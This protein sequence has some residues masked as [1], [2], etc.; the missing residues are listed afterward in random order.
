LS[1]AYDVLPFMHILFL[2]YN[3]Q[4]SNEIAIFQFDFCIRS[5]FDARQNSIVC[6]QISKN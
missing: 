4:V 3:R 1:K 5:Y 2:G 6:S